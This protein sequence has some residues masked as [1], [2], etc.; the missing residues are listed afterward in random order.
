MNSEQFR[1]QWN[2][3]KGELQRRYGQFTNDDLMEIEGDYT[4]FVGTLQKRYG[5]RQQEIQ[6]WAKNWMEQRQVRKAS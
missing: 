5:D 2:V 1:G 4:K 3:F 6:D